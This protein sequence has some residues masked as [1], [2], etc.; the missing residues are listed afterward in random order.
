MSVNPDQAKGRIKQAVGDLAGNKH[1]KKDGKVDERAGNVKA[2][3]KDVKDKA[4]TAVDRIK[5][6]V[7]KR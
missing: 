4:D 7:T 6:K 1:L 5:A 2:V 3:I